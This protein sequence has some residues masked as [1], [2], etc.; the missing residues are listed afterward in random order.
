MINTNINFSGCTPPKTRHFFRL[1]C[2][3]VPGVNRGE[4]VEWRICGC[5][6]GCALA[7]GCYCRLEG[8]Q[9]G[10][11]RSGEGGEGRGAQELA[12]PRRCD[13]VMRRGRESGSY[14]GVVGWAG[15]AVCWLLAVCPVGGG[16]P[17]GRSG[18]AV[19]GGV[20][21][22]M[23]LGS[24]ALPASCTPR[25]AGLLNGGLGPRSTGP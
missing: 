2:Y 10:G 20:A 19:A 12:K 4:G 6:R 24:R 8:V 23:A 14:T 3:C 25:K 1:N 13:R 21:R 9:G 7:G 18:L 16:S 5:P 22:T 17:K 15:S 11:E